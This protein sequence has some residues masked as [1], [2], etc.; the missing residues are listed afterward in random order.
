MKSLIFLFLLLASSFAVANPNVVSDPTTVTEVTHCAWYLD[1]APRQLVVAPQDESG[2]PYCE[3]D[4]SGISTGN[5]TIQAAFVIQDP[6][7]GEQEGPLSAP[8]AFT[9]PSAPESAP[10]AIRLIP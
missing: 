1:S 2:N 9:R 6:I 7:W 10:A 3:L 8:L 5:H 4:I